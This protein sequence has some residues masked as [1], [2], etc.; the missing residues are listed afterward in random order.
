MSDYTAA[1]IRI[2][3]PTEITTRF[4]WSRVAALAD[5]YRRPAAWIARGLEACRRAG[6]SEDYFIGRY[7]RREAIAK[8]EGVDQQ[9]RELATE[10]RQAT[11]GPPYPAGVTGAAER[12][13]G[14]RADLL[15][16]TTAR[17]S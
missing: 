9:M 4:T 7:L 14:L 16:A 12:G 1:S 13:I 8:D 2:L 3:E 6:V 15:Q 5:E 17:K 10:A 11:A